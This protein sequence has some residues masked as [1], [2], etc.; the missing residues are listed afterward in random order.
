MGSETSTNQKKDLRP[1]SLYKMYTKVRK[2]NDSRVGEITIYK[3][4]LNSS[5]VA[6]K[7]F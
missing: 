5:L 7:E 6:C 2:I 1:L 4:R 3:H